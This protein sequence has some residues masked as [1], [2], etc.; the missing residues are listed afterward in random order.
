MPLSKDALSRALDYPYDIPKTS[1][2]FDPATGAAQAIADVR[3]VE[4]DVS[5]HNDHAT[6]YDID[7]LLDGK[8]R[9]LAKV[10]PVVAS[11]SN[12]AP[13]QLHR[14]FQAHSADTMFAFLCDFEDVMPVFSTHFSSYGAISACLHRWPGAASR[15]FVNLL[16]EAELS[17]MHLTE[18]LGRHYNFSRLDSPVCRLNGAAVEM[19]LHYY[20]SIQDPILDVR[21]RPIVVSSFDV[22]KHPLPSAS[23]EQLLRRVMRELF[24]DMKFEDAIA[25][26]VN[27]K[28]KRV[29]ATERLKDLRV[30]LPSAGARAIA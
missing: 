8:P 21:G 11:G 26:I 14:K 28:S 1:F 13:R 5:H 17:R 22:K 3:I 7:V 18:S 16:G 23:A 30:V 27:S 19:N 10:C 12:A 20:E 4:W 9:R 2:A 29:A 24:P 15:L 25:G 6:F